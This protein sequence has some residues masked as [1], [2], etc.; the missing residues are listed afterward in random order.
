MQTL[1]IH[2]FVLHCIAVIF[3]G[4]FSYI[5]KKK[6]WENVGFLMLKKTQC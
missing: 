6:K 2:C 5:V 3:C 1:H 4:K